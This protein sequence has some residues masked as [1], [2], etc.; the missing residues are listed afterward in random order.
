MMIVVNR[1]PNFDVIKTAFPII[2]G[3]KGIVY[4]YG[5]VIYNPDNGVID[6]P[7]MLHEAT[8]SLQQDEMGPEAWWEQYLNDP[9]FRL[10]QELDAYRNQ[11][12]RLCE[13]EK[14]RNRR[15][16]YLFRIASDLS[17]AQYGS[18]ISLKEARRL[19]ALCS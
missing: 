9:E 10:N 17:S 15:A 14:D 7:L 3:K 6:H 12:R 19:I 5:K 13:L 1:P 18:I 11:Y 2:E 16:S 4:T 8:H